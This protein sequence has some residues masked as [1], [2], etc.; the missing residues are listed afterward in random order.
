[1]VLVSYVYFSS[2]RLL[3]ARERGWTAR[4][5]VHCGPQALACCLSGFRRDAFADF[6]KPIDDDI[7]RIGAILFFW[8][9]RD[10]SLVIRCDIHL[11]I[12]ALEQQLRRSGRK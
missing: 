5:S 1:M 11:G 3:T 12:P 8:L 4:F 7:E 2:G 6:V 10:E 9:Q